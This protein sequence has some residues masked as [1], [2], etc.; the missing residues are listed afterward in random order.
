[1]SHTREDDVVFFLTL[2]TIDSFDLFLDPILLE[3]LLEII[4]LGLVWSYET[5]LLWTY[6][7]F[8]RQVLKDLDNFLGFSVIEE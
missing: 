3:L 6:T 2:P 8:I 1:M 4:Y 7:N 5:N